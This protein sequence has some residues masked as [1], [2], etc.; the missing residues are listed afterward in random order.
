MSTLSHTRQRT[1]APILA[2]Y[3]AISAT[4]PLVPHTPQV[5]T[6]VVISAL[7]TSISIPPIALPSSTPSSSAAITGTSIERT[8]SRGARG[9]E[10]LGLDPLRRVAE[11][12][13]VRGHRLHK[14]R[15][16]AHVSERRRSHRPGHLGH[17]L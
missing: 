4:C 16:P 7:N 2:W 9:A 14:V 12:H 1:T 15:G 8:V 10:P 13:Q 3:T 5:P 17:H 6:A 11:R